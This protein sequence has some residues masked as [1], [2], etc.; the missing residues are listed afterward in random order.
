MCDDCRAANLTWKTLRDYIPLF[1]LC[2]AQITKTSIRA[3]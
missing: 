1:E 2:Y 3:H